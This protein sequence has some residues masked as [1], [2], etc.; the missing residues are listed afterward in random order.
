MEE[1][2]S[3]SEFEQ[4]CT[5]SL[6]DKGITSHS[7]RCHEDNVEQKKNSQ[8]VVPYIAAWRAIQQCDSVASKAFVFRSFQLVKP[9]LE[10]LKR[11]NPGSVLGMTRLETFDLESIYFIPAFINNSLKFVRPVI[12]LDAAHLRSEFKGLLYIA[13]TLTGA[14]GVFPIGFMIATGNED[15]RTWVRMLTNLKEACPI[16]SQ[17]GGQGEGLDDASLPNTSASNRATPFLFVS[18]RDKGLKETVKEVFP[19]MWNSVARSTYELTCCRGLEKMLPNTL[20]QL[21]KRTQPGLSR[22]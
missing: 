18:D 20:W 10:E 4:G 13:S 3:S 5:E 2:L 12:S 15:R 22:S 9:Y 21:P 19:T 11:A 8:Q 17:Q 16:I 7:A 1:T 6:E 14:N